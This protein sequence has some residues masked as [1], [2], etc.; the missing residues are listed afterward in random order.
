MK[1]TKTKTKTKTLMTSVLVNG[2][3]PSFNTGLSTAMLISPK[4][5]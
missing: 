4:N 5:K 3:S 1:K 2:Q